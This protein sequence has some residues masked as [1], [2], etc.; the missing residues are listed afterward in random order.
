MGISSLRIA[1]IHDHLSGHTRQCEAI[2]AAIADVRPVNVTRLGIGPWSPLRGHLTR[3]FALSLP[4]AEMFLPAVVRG[5]WQQPFDLIVSA[6]GATTAANVLLKRRNRARNIYSGVARGIAP[7]DIDCILAHLRGQVVTPYHV[8]SLIPVL[9]FRPFAERPPFRGLAGARIGIALGGEARGDGFDFSD[10]YV[11]VLLARLRAVDAT[12]PGISWVVVASR[13]TPV[14]SYAAIAEFAA[15]VERCE[16]VDGR[17]GRDDS[18]APVYDADAVL[19]TEDSRT[20]PTEFMCNGYP[21]VVLAVP[22]IRRTPAQGYLDSL[23]ETG[24]V[25]RLDPATLDAPGLAAAFAGARVT[26]VDV[27]AYLRA[28]IA[29]RLPEIVTPA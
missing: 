11:R 8:F 18:I 28:R 6:S 23:R 15:A 29:E 7:G 2:V 3:R 4:G 13:R 20:M 27:Y 19:V 22:R 14:A 25:E 21:T 10:D 24:A 17:P 26:S 9:R 5:D 1:L 16:V 12:V